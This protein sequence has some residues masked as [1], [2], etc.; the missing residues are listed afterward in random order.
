MSHIN[1]E[2]KARCSEHEKIREILKANNAEFV[3]V[4]YQKDTY[5]KT[6]SGRLKLRQGNIENYLIFYKRENKKQAKESRIILFEVSPNSP[7]E[8]IL[9]D[10]LGIFIEVNKRREIYF[11]ENVKFHLDAIEGLG[12]F[13]EIEAIDK[14]GTIEKNKLLKQCRHY[15]KLFGIDEKNLISC[16][17]SDLLIEKNKRDY[18]SSTS[19]V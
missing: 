1:I 4:D 2:I 17:Y 6:K 7:L 10:S 3:G 15:Q 8:S 9:E 16:S 5:F 13:V 11:I 19:T 18:S 12:Y 14:K